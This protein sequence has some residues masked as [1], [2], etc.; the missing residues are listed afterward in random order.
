MTRANRSLYTPMDWALVRAPLLP[1]DAAARAGEPADPGCLLPGSPAVVAAIQVASGD[2]AAALA[3]TQP[4]H[5]KARRVGRKLLRYLIRMSTRPTPF[6]LFAG[7]ALADWGHRTDLALAK[8]EP[9]AR[10]RTRPDLGW[11]TDLVAHLEADPEVR[12]RLRLVADPSVLVRAGRAFPAGGTASVR[13]T[14]AVRQALALARAPVSRA[15]LAEALITLPGAT[16][17]KA[18]GLIED[19]LRQGF[20]HHDLRPPLTRDPLG[21]VRERLAGHPVAEDLAGLRAALREWDARPLDE[22]ARTWPGLLDRITTIASPTDPRNLLQTDLALPLSGTGL[23]RRIGAQAAVAAEV[24]LRLSPHPAGPPHLDACRRAFER[25]YGAGREVPLLELVDPDFGLGRPT[26]GGDRIH[27]PTARQRLLTD[28]AVNACR[29]RVTAVELDDDLLARLQTW[30]PAAA[31]PPPTLDLAVLVAA[32]SAEAVDKGDFLLVVGPNLGANGAGRTLG[33]FAD[34]LGPPAATALARAAEAESRHAPGR[35]LAEVVYTPE[36][37]RSGNVAVRRCGHRH[38][39]RFGPSTG[40]AEEWVVPVGELVVGLRDGLFTVRWP[41]RDVEVVATQCHMLNPSH[42]PPAARFLLDAAR[43]GRCVFT[44]FDWGPAA[45]LPFLPRIQR[46]RVVLSLAR[47]RVDPA[48]LRGAGGLAAWRQAYGVP[49][50]VYLAGGDNRLLLDLDDPEQAGLLRDEP[51]GRP[52]LLQEAL[53]HPDH[54]WLPG[55]EGFHLSEV[56]VPLALRERRTVPP[57]RR[58]P[59]VVPAGARVRPPGSDWLYLK[60]YGPR[61]FEDELIVDSLRPFGQFVTG[62]GLAD[63][64]FFL[65]YTDPD[66]HLRIRFHGDPATLLG[67]LMRH[68]CDWA[69]DLIS[70]GACATFAFDTYEREIER[71][72]GLAGMPAAEGVFVADSPAVAGLLALSRS[73]GF[74]YDR[75]TV[76]ALSV[77]DLLD[78]LGLDVEQRTRFYRDGVSPSPDGGRDY[79]RRSRELRRLLRDPGSLGTTPHDRALT[80]LLA[81]R[82]RNLPSTYPSPSVCRSHVHLHC[83]RLL[84]T[85]HEPEHRVLELLRR[86]REGLAHQ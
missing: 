33:R 20:L 55:P 64:W 45:A 69:A 52:V 9:R 57:L 78:A 2:L 42:A 77:D 7:V 41:A 16:P 80:S 39:I 63:G 15:E 61:R 46:G 44:S 76:A 1:V 83:N 75:A 70:T 72:G 84:G 30:T 19:L 47:W 32:P 53:P 50:H 82:R 21:H 27:A 26:D 65:R 11:L 68:V 56:V 17:E 58:S 73:H 8:Q 60:L 29:D 24:L 62:A 22:R 67:P 85:G 40:L 66:P 13:A 54:A 51:P 36:R 48:D 79:R 28:L 71:Y 23:N 14:S 25:R 34:L 86:T 38:E 59:G 49:R 10:T 6:G 35:L 4:G 5:P 37:A 74:P 3:R 81:V 12:T 18:D 43:D 31:P